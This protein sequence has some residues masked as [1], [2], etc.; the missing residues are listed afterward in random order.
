MTLNSPPY[1]ENLEN[2]EFCHFLFQAWKMPGIC[3]KSGKTWNINTKHRKNLKFANYMFQASLFKMSFTKIILIYFFIIS[4]LSTQTLIRSQIDIGFH[5]FYLEITWKI[6]GILCHKRSGNPASVL[7]HFEIFIT[8]I[9]T[10]VPG[11][12]HKKR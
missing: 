12:W 4:T 7:A 3:S 8:K 5:C 6:H 1:L 9:C 2:L 10:K 11:I